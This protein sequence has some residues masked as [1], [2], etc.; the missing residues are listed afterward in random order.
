MFYKKLSCAKRYLGFTLIETMVVVVVLSI[1][2]SLSIASYS[3]RKRRSE[4]LSA[5][6]NV[7]TIA[8]AEK[9]ALLTTGAYIG[10]SNT[11]DVN[12]LL[13]LIIDDGNFHNYTVSVLTSPVYSFIVQ[14]EYKSATTYQFYETGDLYSCTG[15]ECVS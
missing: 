9:A 4:Y 6:A 15:P 1:L 5:V 2:A 8:G 14:V 10:A 11:S 13:G 12:N 3:N 7:R